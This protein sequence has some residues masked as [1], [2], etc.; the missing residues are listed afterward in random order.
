MCIQC[1]FTGVPIGCFCKWH[2][3]GLQRKDHS[4]KLQ[5]MRLFPGG[6]SNAKS[7]PGCTVPPQACLLVMAMK[8]ARCCLMSLPMSD[9]A[10]VICRKALQA[11]A[12]QGQLPRLYLNVWQ[13]TMHLQQL[14]THTLMTTWIAAQP[15]DHC[16]KTVR[17]LTLANA[18]CSHEE[19]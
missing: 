13:H 11:V 8:R 14:R 3:T 9:G 5:F 7:F 2:G 1:S 18:S 6:V 4:F 19:L 10:H 15:K 17:K 16:T 12:W